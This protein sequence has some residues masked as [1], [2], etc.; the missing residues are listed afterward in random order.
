MHFGDKIR[1]RLAN[2]WS[3]HEWHMA[4]TSAVAVVACSCW[5]LAKWHLGMGL[6]SQS[7]LARH[8]RNMPGQPSAD[9]Q[10]ASD[11]DFGTAKCL[12]HY[13]TARRAPVAQV[14]YRCKTK[15]E[16]LMIN[17]SANRPRLTHLQSSSVIRAE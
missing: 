4:V 16:P 1:H 6:T 5:D 15:P 9:P 12:Q 7:G 11:A 2:G 14:N 17:R 13:T 3:W 10:R 8:A